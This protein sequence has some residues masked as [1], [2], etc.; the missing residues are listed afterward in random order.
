MQDLKRRMTIYVP[1]RHDEVDMAMADFLNNYPNRML[2]KIL[3]VREGHRA[4]QVTVRVPPT[5]HIPAGAGPLWPRP[6]MSQH[7]APNA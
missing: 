7:G 3:F 5:Q 6:T 2:L 4:G 1:E